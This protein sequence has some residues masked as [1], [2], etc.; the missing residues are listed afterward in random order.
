[1]C[2]YNKQ[3]VLCA[4]RNEHVAVEIIQIS[5][6]GSSLNKQ[7]TATKPW[8]WN[9]LPATALCFQR[10]AVLCEELATLHSLNSFP[11][12]LLSDLGRVCVALHGKT[13]LLLWLSVCE[14]YFCEVGV[15]SVSVFLLPVFRAITVVVYEECIHME[16]FPMRAISSCISSLCS[17]IHLL[18]FDAWTALNWLLMLNCNT[19][20]EYLGA[21][22][23]F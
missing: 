17:Y 19:I 2:I 7:P 3:G 4:C 14:S 13:V 20:L 18:A 23:V 15:L 16:V 10:A 11:D 22:A 6:T 1:M 21:L 9:Y 12:G 8:A 5:A